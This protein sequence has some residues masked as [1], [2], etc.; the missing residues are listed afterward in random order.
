M[1]FFFEYLLPA[2]SFGGFWEASLTLA[3]GFFFLDASFQ[4]IFRDTQAFLAKVVRDVVDELHVL[5]V[6]VCN[7]RKIHAICGAKFSM[8]NHFPSFPELWPTQLQTSHPSCVRPRSGPPR[9]GPATQH[10][11][12]H[13][14]H[15]SGNGLVQNQHASKGYRLQHSAFT[16]NMKHCHILPPD[17]LKPKPAYNQNP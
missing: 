17:F 1:L 13:H 12:L 9:C 2:F 5:S 14:K 11:N 15:V 10:Q 8:N 4:V 7:C 16:I 3:G 6:L